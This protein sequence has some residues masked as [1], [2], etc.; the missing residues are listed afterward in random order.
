MVLTNT[1]GVYKPQ[2]WQTSMKRDTAKACLKQA[3]EIRVIKKCLKQD[4]SLLINNNA[5]PFEKIRMMNPL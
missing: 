3:S 4:P 1:S 2:T 5:N